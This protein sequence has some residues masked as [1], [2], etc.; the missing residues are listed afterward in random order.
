MSETQVPQAQTGQVEIGTSPRRWVVVIMLMLLGAL[1]VYNQI[2]VGAL[3]PTLMEQFNMSGT[4]LANMTLAPLIGSIFL[5]LLT[6]NLADK[7]GPALIC[8]LFFLLT[9]AGAVLRIFINSFVTGFIA[10][11]LM[12]IGAA[13]MGANMPK[14]LAAWFKPSQMALAVSICMIGMASGTGL[15]QATGAL[16]GEPKRAFTIC[17]VITGVLVLAFWLLVTERPKGQAALPLPPKAGSAILKATLRNPH[18]WLIAAAMALFSAWQMIFASMLPT[19]LNLGPAK[20]ELA[21]AGAY[22]SAFAWG[23]LAGCIICPAAAAALGK[24]KPVIMVGSL[25]AGVSI[26]LAWALAPSPIMMLFLA[27]SGVGGAAISCLIT[28]APALLPSVGPAKAGTAGG[29]MGTLTPIG[30]YVIPSLIC[31]PIAGENYTMLTIMGAVLV[32]ITLFTVLG[33][34]EFAPPKKP[35]VVK[36]A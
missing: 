6:G 27:L 12:G 10:M 13:A 35:K 20:M 1:G 31:V 18:V 9:V 33:L 32:A 11:L 3:G 2:V 8:K 5:G 14:L 26:Y 23:G 17:A 15:A 4:Q 22:T 36:A 19:M 25:L 28:T 7:Y 29:L 16:L 30:G 34:P 21:Q 24:I